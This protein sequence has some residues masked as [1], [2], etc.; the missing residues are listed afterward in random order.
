MGG[1]HLRMTWGQEVCY[2]SLHSE[3]ASALGLL[4]VWSLWGNPGMAR[5]LRDVNFASKIHPAG[6][7]DIGEQQ[8]VTGFHKCCRMVAS[9]PIWQLSLSGPIQSD[10]LSIADQMIL[11][12]GWHSHGKTQ[13][14]PGKQVLVR[15]WQWKIYLFINNSVPLQDFIRKTL[16]C[17]EASKRLLV[18]YISLFG[19]IVNSLVSTSFV[20]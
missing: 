1:W 7:S 10:H 5:L 11:P 6:Q 14:I 18:D 13:Y 17:T 8:W 4:T 2:A 12:L 16:L 3:P 20:Y 9:V 19:P 15:S